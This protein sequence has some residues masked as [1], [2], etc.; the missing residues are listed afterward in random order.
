MFFI[1]LKQSKILTI[2]QLYA[3]VLALIAVSAPPKIANV[4]NTH[5]VWVLFG[6]WAIYGYRDIYPLGTFTLEPLDLQEGWLMWA[7]LAVLTFAA[8]VIPSFIPTQYV[9]FDPKVCLNLRVCYSALNSSPYHTEPGY[10]YQPRTDNLLV[11]VYFL[12]FPGRYHH[13]GVS[14]PTPACRRIPSVG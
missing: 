14:S 3:S 12:L 1:I 10:G 5:L 8:V 2:S 6:T 4:A 13:Q 11:L 7:K 9:P